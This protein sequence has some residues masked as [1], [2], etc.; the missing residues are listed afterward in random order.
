[1]QFVTVTEI[2]TFLP[3][4]TRDFEARID[5]DFWAEAGAGEAPPPPSLVTLNVATTVLSISIVTL[6]VAAG[7]QPPPVHPAKVEPESAVAV[8]ETT[9]PCR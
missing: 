9:V 1:M 8:S 7:P 2:T 3:A 5:A 6:H 4:T